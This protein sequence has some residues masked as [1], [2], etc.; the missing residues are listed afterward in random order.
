MKTNC[1]VSHG[2]EIHDGSSSPN[3]SLGSK[4]GRASQK[5]S[6]LLLNFDSGQKSVSDI[7]FLTPQ[8]LAEE[9]RRKRAP[10]G[11]VKAPQYRYRSVKHYF[12]GISEYIFSAIKM[13]QP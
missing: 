4:I 8:E 7:N 9:K 13:E 12:D 1:S 3:E 2:P 6:K 10:K 5:V 11:L